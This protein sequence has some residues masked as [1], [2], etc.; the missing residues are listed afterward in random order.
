M[1]IGKGVKF[2]RSAVEGPIIGGAFSLIDTEGRLV[3]EKKLL[4]NWVLIY[5]GYT[6]SPDIGPAEVQK[7]ANAIRILG[8]ILLLLSEIP[9][10]VIFSS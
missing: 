3:T 1:G 10:S 7:M 9:M 6:S 4:G 2:E 5:F 8:S